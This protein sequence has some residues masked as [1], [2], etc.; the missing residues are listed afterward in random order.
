M[1]TVLGAGGQ[2]AEELTRELHRSFT[3]DIRLLPTDDATTGFTIAS[4]V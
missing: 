1:Q 3:R 2:I 4:W